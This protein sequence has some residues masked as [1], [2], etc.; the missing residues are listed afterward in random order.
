MFN[1]R[2]FFLFLIINFGINQLL[3]TGS[4]ITLLTAQM[5]C[6]LGSDG[7]L[8]DASAIDWYN[9]PDDDT[10]MLPPPPPPASNGKLTT[11]VSCCSG[12]A[13][14]LTEKICDAANAGPAK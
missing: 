2:C 6:A 12:Q 13:I 5:S 8:K 11:F 14:K 1:V 9:D 7:Q 10:P 4:I 3:T